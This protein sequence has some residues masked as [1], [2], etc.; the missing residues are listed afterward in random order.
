MFPNTNTKCLMRGCNYNYDV[1][2]DIMQIYSYNYNNRIHRH[3]YVNSL[4]ISILNNHNYFTIL[5]PNIKT[6]NRIRKPDLII[7]LYNTAYLIDTQISIETINT[8]INYTIKT[9]YYNTTDIIAYDKKIT[10]ANRTL[11]SESCWN[12]FCSHYR[13]SKIFLH[14]AM[15]TDFYSRIKLLEDRILKLESTSPE[16]GA[17]SISLSR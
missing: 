5:E 15:P 6:L 1:L 10:G 2:N 7:Y 9:N 14:V 17:V 3:N 16:Y 11:F 8:D 12:S 13:I 4:L